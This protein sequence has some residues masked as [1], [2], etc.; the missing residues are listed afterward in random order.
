M[1]SQTQ[2]T[3]ECGF[4][5]EHDTTIIDYDDPDSQHRHA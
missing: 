3:D 4:E 1:S 5:D 2:D